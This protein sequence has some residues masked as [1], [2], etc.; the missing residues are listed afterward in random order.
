MQR[1]SH[2]ILRRQPRPN[3]K[4][5]AFVHLRGERV[6]LG[7]WGSQEAKR[8]YRRLCAELDANGGRLAVTAADL[9]VVELCARF[10]V[11]AQ[12]YYAKADGKQTS[13]VGN[14]KCVLSILKNL[15]GLEFVTAFG[16]LAL[17]AC[18]EEMLKR[19]WTRKTINANVGRIRQIF[20]W[21]VENEMVNTVTYQALCAVKG[22][23]KGKTTAR[24]GRKVK[25][26]PPEHIEKV[27]PLVGRIVAAMVEL[28]VLSGMRPA[29]VCIMRPLDLDRTGAIWV[30]RPSKYKTEHIE[31]GTP[32]EVFLGPKAQEVLK[33]FL[34]R[35]QAA[36]CFSPLEA[37][38]ARHQA[39]PTHR[40]QPNREPATERKIGA[41]YTSC[42][43][44]R[45][46]E[47]ACDTAGIPRWTPNRLRHSTATALQSKFGPEVARI[48]LGHTSVDTTMIYVDEDR[49]KARRVMGE[50]G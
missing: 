3:G 16:P 21:G 45:C 25:A 33:P 6:Y 12:T 14:F 38:Q 7:R 8:A 26:A 24:E 31:D 1:N 27:K 9:T 39:C 30:Y 37:E 22:L 4:D 36:Y 10:H 41:C 17:K 13:E 49:E 42:S 11:H 20:R 34:L 28:Q 47:R 29:E 5:S 23:R 44:R 40:H 18:R 46:I 15:Y 32:R 35:D 48:I 43:Y 50:V 2:P 19:G